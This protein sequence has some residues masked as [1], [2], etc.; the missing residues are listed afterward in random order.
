MNV[1]N[2]ILLTLITILGA[3]LLVTKPTNFLD[4][5]P[6]DKNIDIKIEKIDNE[7]NQYPST[8][9]INYFEI[10]NYINN[11]II[12]TSAFKKPKIKKSGKIFS[13]GKYS[14]E[15][16]WN[17][18]KLAYLTFTHFPQNW[19]NYSYL[20]FDIYSE[21]ENDELIIVIGDY[22]DS[23]GF[24]PYRSKY[25][26]KLKLTKRWNYYKFSIEEISRKIDIT[27]ERKNIN[28]TF[29]CNTLPKTFY[30]DNIRL[31]L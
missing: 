15:I 20:S 25:T 28:F 11:I 27:S 3:Y 1:S 12:R 13:E 17:T 24:Y 2:I 18:K 29:N 10:D 4:I 26:K 21:T 14:L 8:Q 30:L 6:T 16:F 22:Y 23:K 19:H 7:I 31:E 9:E 5:P